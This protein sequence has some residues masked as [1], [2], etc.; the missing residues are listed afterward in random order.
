MSQSQ[1]PGLPTRPACGRHTLRGLRLGVPSALSRSA[2]PTATAATAATAA[3][4][5]RIDSG[6]PFLPSPQAAAGPLG[7][8]RGTFW[9]LPQTP[10]RPI[11]QPSRLLALRA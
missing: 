10:L 8:A 5:A 11:G 9:K 4:A 2:D 6:H 1:V 3:A 7:L